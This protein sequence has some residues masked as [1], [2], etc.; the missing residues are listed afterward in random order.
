MAKK[1]SKLAG[2]NL[3]AIVAIVAGLAI[4]GLAFIPAAK[5]VTDLAITETVEVYNF[6]T[7]IGYAFSENA[8]TELV[9]MGIFDLIALI[10]A[11]LTVVVGVLL[12]LDVLGKKFDKLTLLTLLIVAVALIGYIICFFVWKANI[13]VIELG[14]ITVNADN[15][16]VSTLVYILLGVDLAGL[17]G[18]LLLKK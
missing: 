12:L 10:F 3:K 9:F 17:A 15:L 18:C 1:K 16:K 4:F 8:A 14:P 7:L 2:L 13:S 5:L 6:Y 11:G